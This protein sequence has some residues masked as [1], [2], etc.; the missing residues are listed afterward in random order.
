MTELEAHRLRMTMTIT[1]IN[2]GFTRKESTWDIY[3]NACLNLFNE[4]KKH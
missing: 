2:L 1:Y 3:S 4:F